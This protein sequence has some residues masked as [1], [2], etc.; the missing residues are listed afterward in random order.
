MDDF[1]I[2]RRATARG[3]R[4]GKPFNDS[5]ESYRPLL[6]TWLIEMTLSLGWYKKIRSGFHCGAFLEEKSFAAI[7]G[8]VVETDS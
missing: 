3:N 7:T 2:F 5:V 6:A 1:K 4:S 8:I